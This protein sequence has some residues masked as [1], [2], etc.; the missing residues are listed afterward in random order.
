MSVGVGAASFPAGGFRSRRPAVVVGH[1]ADWR[2]EV[3]PGGPW[4]HL[5]LAVLPAGSVGRTPPVETAGVW[6]PP[7]PGRRGNA[8]D[9]NAGRPPGCSLRTRP[10]FK[11]A[12]F[13]SL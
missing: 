1:P 8:G 13:L 10:R 3:K 7:T 11:A 2:F 5:R 12:L 4:L 6:L 9:P